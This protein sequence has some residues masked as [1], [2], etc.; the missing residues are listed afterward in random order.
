MMHINKV[1]EM[2][3][4][5]LYGLTMLLIYLKLTDQ[6]ALAWRWVLAPV[7]MPLLIIAAIFIVEFLYAFV[8]EIIGEIKKERENE[9][10]MP[11][12]GEKK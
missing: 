7:M 2:F 4:W 12:S 6:I 10:E 3:C 8:L 1:H 11:E 9:V 5:Q